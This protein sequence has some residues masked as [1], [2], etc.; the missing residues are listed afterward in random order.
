MYKLLFVCMGNICRSP[1]A[2]GFFSHHLD[3][4][5][6]S[7]RVSTD[8]AGTHSYHIGNSPD[9]RAISEAGRFGVD[10][11]ALRARKISVMDF[12]Q[13]DLILAMDKHN[14]RLIKQ[15]Q[16]ARSRAKLAL[17]M[18]YAPS[19]GVE[20]VPDPYYG[21]QVDFTLMCDLL[22]LATKNLLRRLETDLT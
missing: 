12:D 8:S 21:S 2:E 17:M 18:E 3:K 5:S 4:S 9:S 22:D 1:S 13:F 19:E 6:I 15:L 20:E 10:I 14:L 7:D 16:P 11:S